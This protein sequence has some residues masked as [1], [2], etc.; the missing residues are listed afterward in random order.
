MKHV[1]SVSKKAGPAYAYA[2][3]WFVNVANPKPGPNAGLITTGGKP[4]V[5]GDL[6][7]GY[8][9]ALW[10][11]PDSIDPTDVNDVGLF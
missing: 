3:D 8:V 10:N 5:P 2:W 6:T 11:S 4:T 7:P 1:R 9:D